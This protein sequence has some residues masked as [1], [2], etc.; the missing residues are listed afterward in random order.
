MKMQSR[1]IFFSILLVTISALVFSACLPNKKV[2]DNSGSS[3]EKEAKNSQEGES[4]TGN[5]KDI[6]GFGKAQKCSWDTGDGIFGEVYTDGTRSYSEI[7][8]VPVFG[9]DD[10]IV[11][12]SASDSETGST[13]TIFDGEYFYTWSSTSKNG[14]KIKNENEDLGKDSEENYMELEEVADNYDE[15]E[16][17]VASAEYNYKCSSWMVNSSKFDLPTN[18]NFQDLSMMMDDLKNS[19]QDISRVCDM[20]EGEEKQN[21]LGDWAKAQQ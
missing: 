17:D 18:I 12:S 13:Y 8:N 9:S 19:A 3:L 20:L 4:F 11:D 16:L 5:L 14:M 10:E 7:N 15:E 6:I 21:C 1:K 2:Q